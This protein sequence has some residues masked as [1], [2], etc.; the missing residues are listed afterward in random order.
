M[1]RIKTTQSKVIRLPSLGLYILAEYTLPYMNKNSIRLAKQA[2]VTTNYNSK[3]VSL[4]FVYNTNRPLNSH[5][6]HATSNEKLSNVVHIYKCHCGND[7]VGRMFS[8]QARAACYKK[9]KWLS[10]G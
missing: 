9:V 3:C 8:F 6:K 10:K 1:K 2:S 7:Y 4:H 5:E